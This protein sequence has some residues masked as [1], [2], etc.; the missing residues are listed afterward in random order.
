MPLI[1]PH[2]QEASST[3][4]RNQKFPDY[5]KATPNS[6]LKKMKRQR[7]IQQVKD[8]EK[9]PSNNTNEEEIGSLADKRVQNNDSKDEP[10]S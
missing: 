1:Q 7:N 8:H 4:K 5:I 10:K 2:P 6:N 9:W 3:I